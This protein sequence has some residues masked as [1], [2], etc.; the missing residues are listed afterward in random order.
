ME[1]EVS[2]LTIGV[3]IR[4]WFPMSKKEKEKGELELDVMFSLFNDQLVGT[5]FDWPVHTLLRKKN[6]SGVK[7]LIQ[8]EK[9]DRLGADNTGTT[10]VMLAAENDLPDCLKLLLPLE[11]SGSVEAKKTEGTAAIHFVRFKIF[12]LFFPLV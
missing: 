4:R 12:L 6:D 8:I 1:I 2:K 10:A 9:C 11:A 3:P 5:E 7:H